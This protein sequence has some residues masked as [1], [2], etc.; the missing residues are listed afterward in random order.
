MKHY[1]LRI[2][3][4]AVGIFVVGMLIWAAVRKGRDTVVEVVESDHPISIPLAFVPFTLDGR[5]LGTLSRVEIVRSTPEQVSAVNFMVKLADSVPDE[6]LAD[7]VLLA[8]DNLDHINPGRAF[9]CG[10]PADTV[11]RQLAPVGQLETQRGGVFVLLARE[12]ALESLRIDLHG[13]QSTDSIAASVE[14]MADSIERT[15]DSIAASAELLVQAADSMRNEAGRQADS[16]RRAAHE[17]RDS[18]RR[19][20]RKSVRESGPNGR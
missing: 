8:K 1:W 14:A 3:G 4:G 2:I 6:R 11:G 17:M 16:A 12:G 13:R 15:A 18:I 9:S 20:V 19:E 7:C 5:S 10:T